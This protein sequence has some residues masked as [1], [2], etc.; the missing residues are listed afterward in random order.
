MFS[1][2]KRIADALESIAKSSETI[3][4]NQER[5]MER[6]EKIQQAGQEQAAK[7]IGQLTGLFLPHGGDQNGR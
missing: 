2:L 5:Q 1:D 7:M 6:A 4:Q 3:L